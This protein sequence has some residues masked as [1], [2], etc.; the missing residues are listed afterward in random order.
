MLDYE[1]RMSEISYK[2]FCPF[3][4]NQGIEMTLTETSPDMQF[5]SDSHYIQN[6]NCD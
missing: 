5:Y 4:I 1:F 6:I 3:E 2:L